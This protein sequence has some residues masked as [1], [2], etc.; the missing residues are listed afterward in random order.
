MVPNQVE[1]ASGQV[2]L[3]LAESAAT[4]AKAGAASSSDDD[5][6]D[7]EVYNVERFRAELDAMEA[8]GED[9]E[10]AAEAAKWWETLPCKPSCTHHFLLHLALLPVSCNGWACVSEACMDVHAMG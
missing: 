4:A 1:E 6:S 2:K 8:D 3:R 7:E 10:A 5:S 9:A